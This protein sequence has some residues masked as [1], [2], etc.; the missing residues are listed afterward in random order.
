MDVVT[1]LARALAKQENVVPSVPELQNSLPRST[2]AKTEQSSADQAVAK[3]MASLVD[4]LQRI[5]SDL[6]STSAH[7]TYSDLQ[8]RARLALASLKAGRSPQ[9][10]DSAPATPQQWTNL[11]NR[12]SALPAE[13][14]QLARRLLT[15]GQEQASIDN[16]TP[17][18]QPIEGQALPCIVVEDAHTPSQRQR[19]TLPR[20]HM[21]TSPMA[22]RAPQAA[23]TCNAETST[24]PLRG[25][26]HAL[27]RAAQLEEP[28]LLELVETLSISNEMLRDTHV[29][30]HE[31][32][33]AAEVAM[34]AAQAA[35]DAQDAQLEQLAVD[36]DA[37]VLELETALQRRVEEYNRLAAEQTELQQRM[38][39]KERLLEELSFLQDAHRDST[40]RAT[41]LEA[42]TQ[43]LHARLVESQETHAAQAQAWA[44]EKE[45]L[46][47]QVVELQG[48]HKEDAERA[49][50]LRTLRSENASQAQTMANLEADLRK[51]YKR[52]KAE[53]KQLDEQYRHSDYAAQLARLQSDVATWQSAWTEVNDLAGQ[54]QSQLNETQHTQDLVKQL[55]QANTRMQSELAAARAAEHQ[56]RLQADAHAT[57]A[58]DLR[59]QLDNTRAALSG[60]EATMTSL[61]K[62][63]DAR[64]EQIAQLLSS[65]DDAE[66]MT[67]ELLELRKTVQVLEAQLHAERAS[68]LRQL[69]EHAVARAE[70]TGL[71][72]KSD[73]L[74]GR[75]HDLEAAAAAQSKAHEAELTVAHEQAS[76]AQEQLH[77]V[78]EDLRE[79]EEANEELQAHVSELNE[80]LQS[81]RSEQEELRFFHLTEEAAKQEALEHASQVEKALREEVSALEQGTPR[82]K[83]HDTYALVCLLLFVTQELE[84]VKS[85]GQEALEHLQVQLETAMSQAE[86][87][88]TDQIASLKAELAYATTKAERLNGELVERDLRLSQLEAVMAAPATTSAKA[89]HEIK[90][91]RKFIA[92]YQAKTEEKIRMLKENLA[93][94]ENENQL[95]DREL[96]R[97]G[98]GAN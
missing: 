31:Q 82:D 12:R 59:T 42:E 26:V 77:Q 66:H 15:E 71:T 48:L 41:A 76:S 54:L 97:L 10:D 38:A 89:E 21:A 86:T 6:A 74:L 52:H 22:D 90:A 9:K 43:V 2:K 32:L 92:E 17:T 93:Q 65:A 49:Q 81:E 64:E 50:E 68:G 58:E 87:Q 1:P 69:V 60:V 67:Q 13:R 40:D 94:S 28:Q 14:V 72:R 3:C 55:E 7:N 85:K 95:L 75:V 83:L 61:E 80:R 29:Q 4:T 62:K 30:L 45:A 20:V 24:S 23:S 5:D 73:Q 51:M 47:T 19:R 56:A 46:Q 78:K 25:V 11:P 79:Q 98:K 96:R 36:H 57:S 18:A 44:V 8:A 34:S 88:S 63:L 33:A 84:A 70:V 53:L 37:R 35:R 27:E 16:Q 39:D 91:L